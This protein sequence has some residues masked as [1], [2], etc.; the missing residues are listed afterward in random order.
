MT[1]NAQSTR[2][3]GPGSRST[4]EAH[5]T[6]T[7]APAMLQRPVAK[8]LYRA[9]RVDPPTNAQLE[10][11]R[12]QIA[13]C[14]PPADDFVAAM[15]R[16]GSKTGR[17][18]FEQALEQGVETV[19]DPLPEL[20][21]YF[22]ALEDVPFWVDY[23][24]LDRAARTVSRVPLRS[25]VLLTTALSFPMSYVGARVNEVLLRGGDL[26]KRAGARVVETV[27]WFVHCTTEGG[28]ER[29]GEGFKSTARIRLIHAYIRAGLDQLDDWD[30]SV[31]GHPVNQVH[32]TVT[33]VPITGVALLTPILGHLTTRRERADI[34]HLFR[35]MSHMMGVGP[36]L[37]VSSIRELMRLVWLAVWS[38][39]DPDE[40]S[41]RLTNAVFAAVPTIYG[42]GD[43]SGPLER[44]TRATLTRVHSDLARATFGRDYA[45]SVKIPGLTPA[46]VAVPVYTAAN[47][48]ADLVR[49]AIPGRSSHLARTNGVRRIEELNRL[50]A[51][52]KAR[53]FERDDAV[54]VITE[55]NRELNTARA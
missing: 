33:M 8:L 2:Y 16:V 46:L 54:E 40:S 49:I 6:T 52:V 36:A 11:F 9:L 41:V 42:V 32:Q 29:F 38:E 50:S 12:K 15:R 18:Q 17:A 30:V 45:D 43:G 13:V 7:A 31:M 28:M 1:I 22:E 44:F 35:Y 34:V 48:V 10:A 39:V 5:E 20:V 25:V 24:T 55:R 47:L 14:D 26:D 37:Q 27:A 4:V 21:A 3:V 51:R 19:A 23:G 53:K